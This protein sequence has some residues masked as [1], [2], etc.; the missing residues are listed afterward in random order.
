[1]IPV[2]LNL[3]NFL[4]YGDDVPTLD[5]TSLHVVCLSGANGHGKSALL[6]AITWATW[7][8]ARKAAGD[9]KPDERLLRMGAVEMA[10][11]FVFETDGERYR[12]LRKY[13]SD[14]GG[15]SSLEFQIYSLEGDGYHTISQG[16]VANTQ[17]MIVETLRMDFRT[18][19]NSVFILQGRADE[20]T[21]RSARERKEILGDILGLWKYDALLD[22]ARIHAQRQDTMRRDGARRLQ[23]I[24]AELEQSEECG[25][26]LTS[27]LSSLDGLQAKKCA[28]DT[29]LK[30]ALIR[31]NETMKALEQVTE[32]KVRETALCIEKKAALRRIE[33]LKTRINT[34]TLADRD[35]VES[36]YEELQ[37]LGVEHEEWHRKSLKDRDLTEQKSVLERVIEKKRHELERERHALT[38]QID[39]LRKQVEDTADVVS[40]RKITEEGYQ[41]CLDAGEVEKSWEERRVK[42]D[43]SDSR[44]RALEEQINKDRTILQGELVGLGHR[45]HE[46]SDRSSQI[47]RLKESA[48][49]KTRELRDLQELEGAQREIEEKGRGLNTQI[50]ILKN[51]IKLFQH[52]D[53][54][55]DAKLAMLKHG[56]GTNCP[57]CDAS[58]DG[59]RRESISM[60]LGEMVRD[61]AEEIQRHEA[62]I[63]LYQEQRDQL[64]LQ[65][66]Q[67]RP[68]LATVQSAQSAVATVESA[69]KEASSAANDM[70]GVRRKMAELEKTVSSGAFAPKLMEEV[71]RCR[72]EKDTI[73]YDTKQHEDSKSLLLKLQNHVTEKSRLDDA[74]PRHERAIAEIRPLE[75]AA[76][77]L[78]LKFDRRDYA[79]DAR[80]QLSAV[81]EDLKILSYDADRHSEVGKRV[82]ILREVVGRREELAQISLQLKASTQTAAEDEEKVEAVTAEIQVLSDRIDNLNRTCGQEDS[83]DREVLRLQAALASAQSELDEANRQLGGEQQRA[84]RLK[85]LELERP[86]VKAQMDQAAKDLQVFEKLATAFGKDGIQALIIENAIPEIE[87]ETNRI[88]SRLTGNR[89][90]ISIEPLRNLKTGGSKETL[91]IHISDEMGT[92]PY[93]MYSGGEAFRTDFALRIALSKLLAGRAG[94]SLRTL[95]ID[96]GFGTQDAEGLDDLIGALHE[97]RNDFDKII[98]VTHLDRL[99]S[100]FPARIEVVKYPDI[101]SMFE[102][103]V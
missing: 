11:E 63:K 59:N 44:I 28:L 35:R 97:I 50:E 48:E 75:I 37:K 61:H 2:S 42:H 38:S 22:R 60:N 51:R 29:E 73:G 16:S 103:A 49:E 14:R 6:D 90:Q 96:E 78:D 98:V 89:T 71:S 58:L 10:V 77:R 64:A 4:S 99:K 20:F 66:K 47:G 19:I 53:E 74:Y 87:E 101:G 79:P 32:L 36:G 39:S 5:F 1:M 46:L 83:C 8:E 94:T 70:Q 30:A 67:N 12:I 56:A 24:D 43:E 21:R 100:A 3:K 91:D 34:Y 84:A 88:L 76:K 93:E 72:R 65:F 86:T 92:R 81:I 80:G 82:G 41:A 52:Q 23:L 62:G 68:L 33:V 13:R 69:I 102:V 85:E 26:K 25:M 17:Q 15:K 40:R 27:L 7:G 45:L 57:L 31:Q 18:F 9:R 95:I 55:A 54:D